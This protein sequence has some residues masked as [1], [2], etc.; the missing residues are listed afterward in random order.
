MEQLK[1]AGLISGF[2]CVLMVVGNTLAMANVEQT[3]LY[4]AAFPGSQP[5][6]VACHIDKLPKKDAG[7]HDPNAYSKKILETDAKPT[8]DTYKKVGTVEAFDAAKPT[9]QDGK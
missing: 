1:K 8:A 5:K 3:K 7:M 2:V 4:K 6:C 9:Q